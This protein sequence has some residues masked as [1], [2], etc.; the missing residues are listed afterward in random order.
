MATSVP[1]QVSDFLNY[2]ALDLG[3]PESAR[4]NYRNILCEFCAYLETRPQ[5]TTLAPEE[6]RS[7]YDGVLAY[8]ESAQAREGNPHFRADLRQSWLY[9]YYE[10]QRNPIAFVEASY[11]VHGS[12]PDKLWAQIVT[13][14]KGILGREYDRWYDTAGTL[15]PER[16][17]IPDYDPTCALAP[18]LPRQQMIVPSIQPRGKS[19]WPKA[20]LRRVVSRSEVMGNRRVL[21]HEEHLECGHLHIEFLGANPGNRRRRCLE[22]RHSKRSEIPKKPVQS[23]TRAQKKIAA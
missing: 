5:P 10:S 12:H 21:Y 3:M 6:G 19:A 17:D 20:P 14:R 2:K 8:L 1:N 11:M 23:V 18:R 9:V 16:L 13:N 7:P 4:E 15:V 22:C